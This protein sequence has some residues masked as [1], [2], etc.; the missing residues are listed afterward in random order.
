MEAQLGRMR[1]NSAYDL[2][3]AVLYEVSSLNTLKA[4]AHFVQS[5]MDGQ[6]SICIKYSTL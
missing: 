6:R 1:S 2:N 3:L 5:L 4:A